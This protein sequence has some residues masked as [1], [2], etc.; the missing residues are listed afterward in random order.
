MQPSE[1]FLFCKKKKQK[2]KPS[3]D[4]ILNT[5]LNKNIGYTVGKDGVISSSTR[6]ID[7]IYP[8]VTTNTLGLSYPGYRGP[9]QLVIYKSTW[10]KRT[11]TNEFGKEAVVEGNTVSRLTGADSII[12]QNGYVISGHGEAKKWISANLRVGTNVSIDEANMKISAYTTVDSFRYY[13]SAKIDEVEKICLEAKT[14]RYSFDDKKVSNYLKRAKFY[15]S[16]SEEN[17]QMGL[18]YA[19]NAAD[20]AQ[21]A[22]NYT[23]PYLE[24]ELKGV[25]LRPSE[26]S[27]SE[28]ENTLNDL[29]KTGINAVFVETY[30]HGK[31][32]Y[33][34]TVMKKYGFSMQSPQFKGFDPLSYWVSEGR[35]RDIETHVWFE[36][37]YIGNKPPSDDPENILSVK[38]QWSNRNKINA[39]SNDL[40]RHAAEHSGYFLDPSNKEV[41][42]FLTELIMEISAKYDIKGVN[43]DYVRYPLSAKPTSTS[44]ESSNWGYTKNARDEFKAMYGIDPFDIKYGTPMWSKW[45]KY[46]Q[47]KITNYVAGVKDVLKDR[48]VL[49]SAVV[50]PD[51]ENCME[52]KQQDWGRWSANG[53]VDAITPL[54]LTSDATLSTTMMK[55]IRKKASS[56]TKVMPGLFVAFMEGEPDDLLRQI[57]AARSINAEG[58]VLFDYAHLEAKYTDILKSCVFTQNCQP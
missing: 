1:A 53:Y 9:N 22:M 55:N 6:T 25:W 57:Y 56:N 39:N 20:M 42:D 46:R 36:S 47:D 23:M 16:K 35:K 24:K 29:K 45:D 27:K 18:V 43:L 32:I 8:S 52:T 58:V 12:P 44:Y 30:Y 17:D 2:Q 19:I 51:E 7:A 34:S 54:I 50:F 48:N 26:K 31:T 37:F 10:A 15:L 14:L 21:Y 33:P 4:K 49:V 38:P 11:G 3:E 13:A 41:T 40:V 28:I 5:P